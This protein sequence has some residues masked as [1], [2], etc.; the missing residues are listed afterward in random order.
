MLLALWRHPTTSGLCLVIIYYQEYNLKDLLVESVRSGT[1]QNGEQK[2]IFLSIRRG[3]W[4]RIYT[5]FC[6]SRCCGNKA[7]S[8]WVNTASA[9]SGVFRTLRCIICEF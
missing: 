6:V 4:H 7:N 3:R 8:C 1:D 2:H 5:R 9:L